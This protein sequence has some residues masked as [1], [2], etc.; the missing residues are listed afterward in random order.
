MPERHGAEVGQGAGRMLLEAAVQ[1]DGER[2]FEVFASRAIFGDKLCRADVGEGMNLDLDLAQTDRQFER[3]VSPFE[4]PIDVFHEHVELRAIAV[5]HGQLASGRKP[6]EHRHRLA[7]IGLRRGL[8]GVEPGQPGEPAQGVA[9]LPGIAQ[10]SPYGKGGFARGHRLGHLIRQVT[11]VG[12]SLEQ[13]R[14]LFIGQRGSQQRRVAK[15]G[16]QMV[17]RLAMGAQRRRAFGGA[18]RKAQHRAAVGRLVGVMDQ[19]ADRDL[20]FG[21]LQEHRQHSGVEILAL[22]QRH[23]VFDRA[24]GDFVVKGQR[25]VGTDDHPGLQAFLQHLAAGRDH[26]VDQPAFGAARH[27]G[28]QVGDLTGRLAEPRQAGD[29]G[30]ADGR[31]NVAARRREHLGHEKRIA[32]RGL[33][34]A[35]RRSAGG[36]G[37]QFDRAFAQGS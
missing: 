35:G 9:L 30:I 20:A 2:P 10:R 34:Q 13:H 1:G 19:A 31:R 3:L 8:A 23:A 16:A 18:G 5:G 32:A 15:R 4:G 25:A 24:A 21:L 36:R 27:D 11:F 33:V 28:D 12:Q 17:G 7:G 26:A 6:L 14:P 29:H 37:Q 22:G